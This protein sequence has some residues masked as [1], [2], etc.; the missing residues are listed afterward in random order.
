MD[1]GWAASCGLDVLRVSERGGGGRAGAWGEG[2]SCGDVS[3]D[4]MTLSTFIDTDEVC[5][6]SVDT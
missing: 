1:G 4:S 3:R 2:P 6:A 5:S